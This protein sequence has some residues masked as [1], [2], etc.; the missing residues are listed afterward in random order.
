MK[1]QL[2]EQMGAMALIDELRHRRMQVDEHLDLPRRREEVAERV[3]AY[4]SAQRIEVDDALIE[5]G[6]R[7]Y[8][9]RRLEFQPA[10][11]ASPDYA[12]ALAYIQA[13]GTGA[14][15]ARA[16]APGPAPAPRGVIGRVGAALARLLR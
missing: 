16:G 10:D 6:V 9:A 12:R 4:Y 7:A 5:Q 15:A 3:R 1:I 11:T 8:F 14:P 13:Q 2:A